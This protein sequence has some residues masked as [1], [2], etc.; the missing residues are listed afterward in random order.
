MIAEKELRNGRPRKYKSPEEMK[1][2]IDEYFEDNDKPTICGLTLA[3]GF[4]ERKAL[5]NYEGYGKK[6]YDT[7][8][9]AKLVVEHYYERNLAIN[10]RATGAI[11]ALK[12]FDWSDKREVSFTDSPFRLNI[13]L[14][15]IQLPQPVK[16]L[17]HTLP[18]VSKAITAKA[19]AVIEPKTPVDDDKSI[20]NGDKP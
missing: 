7:I 12:N 6:F 13:T 18:V 4:C 2:R 9:R 5:L 10:T 17:P 11:F 3:L 20:G 16:P 15:P 8:K 14:P 1:A 19:K